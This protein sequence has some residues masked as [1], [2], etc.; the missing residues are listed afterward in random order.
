MQGV[1]DPALSKAVAWVTAIAQVRS[2]ALKLPQVLGTAKN[3]QTNRGP[4]AKGG[5]SAGSTHG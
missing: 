5:V 2:L 4:E 3:K 1:K